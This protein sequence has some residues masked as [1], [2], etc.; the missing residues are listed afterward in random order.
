MFSNIS[1]LPFCF[2]QSIGSNEPFTPKL[3]AL[4]LDVYRTVRD[5]AL[6]GKAFARPCQAAYRLLSDSRGGARALIVYALNDVRRNIA[7][8]NIQVSWCELTL[9]R[10]S[11]NLAMLATPLN[12]G[13]EKDNQRFPH[14]GFGVLGTGRHQRG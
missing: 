10:I 3:L 5:K 1:G 6:I 14:R 7:A 8:I 11:A 12:A 13:Y 9:S 4:R 2:E